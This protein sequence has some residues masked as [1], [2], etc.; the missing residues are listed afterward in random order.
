[1]TLLP[2]VFRELRV[3]SRRRGT[4][5]SRVLTA[6]AATGAGIIVYIFNHDDT[7]HNLA[8]VLFE[9]VSWGA[10]I[11]CLLTGI[12]STAD[13]VSEEKRD[14]TL[15][16]LFLTDLKGYD[17]VAGKL[18][19]TSLNSFYGL[20]A[21][22]PVLAIPLLMGG[23][24][25]GEFWRIAMVLANTFF[26][27]LAVGMLMSAVCES[28]RKAM[29]FTFIVLI[30]FSVGLG[31]MQLISWVERSHDVSQFLAVL[32]PAYSLMEAVDAQY[33]PG[34]K[35]FWWSAALVHGVA[36]TCLLV[37]S[38]IVPRSWQDRPTGTAKTGWRAQWR[39]LAYGAS[40]ARREFRRRLLGH[41][42]FYWLAARDRLKPAYVWCTLAAGAAVWVWAAIEFSNDWTFDFFFYSILFNVMF[43]LW[44]ASESGRRLGDDRKLGSLELILST[45]ISI[46]EILY[47]QFLALRRQ[48][49]GPLL[50]VLVLEATLLVAS[51]RSS[52]T[53]S[54]LVACY[55]M[56]WI[57]GTIMLL[58]DLAALMLVGMWVSLTAKNPNRATGITVARVLVLPWAITLGICLLA[59]LYSISY[60]AY[61]PGWKSW[62]AVWYVPGY[63]VS[64][65][66]GTIAWRR[67]HTQ[68]REVAAHR[69]I[70]SEPW[71]RSLFR[72]APPAPTPASSP[73]PET[74]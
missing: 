19:A 1:M 65:L 70:K 69:F 24:T 54:S 71:L 26:F 58:G 74:I 43:K 27:S 64:L 40:H 38:L 46:P 22:F 50:A 48:F 13:C 34:W 51:L 23:V 57:G 59:V 20:T 2:I 33:A 62:L 42:A 66:L 18:V 4:Y 25:N 41:N 68:F 45:P 67:L 55:V 31:L 72:S 56:F 47:G 63:V 7:P 17:V 61:S 8:R 52:E 16:L 35:E 53:D 3:A 73:A 49:L 29:A 15:G 39:L 9:T 36:W 37:A 28:A 14:G 12:R 60:E 44:V 5:W 6:V 21:I 30:F 10:F 11:Y 32:N